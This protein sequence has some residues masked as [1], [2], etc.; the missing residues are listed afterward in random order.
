MSVLNSIRATLV[1]VRKEGAPFI[2]AALLVAIAGLFLWQPLFWIA[3]IVAAWVAYF[4]RDPQRV[5]PIEPDLVVSP[6]DGRVSA[7]VLAVPPAELGLGEATRRR[8]SVFMNVFDCH[9]NRA[10]VAGKVAK[11]V[12]KPGKFLSAD[13]DKA[14][15][16]NE[17]NGIVID[18]THG[19]VGVVQIA[20]LVARRIVCFAKEGDA[21]APGERIGMIRFGSRLDVWLPAAAR[22]LVAEG[23]IA[24]AGETV[25]ARFGGEDEIRRVRVD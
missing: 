21:L 22:V 3:V 18:S 24:I 23:Q 8:V 6:A 2:A 13:L 1:P 10:P 12:Y 9:V 14:S 15:E 25:L 4:F 19:P 7:V 17:R 20:G 5:V 11:I 16:D